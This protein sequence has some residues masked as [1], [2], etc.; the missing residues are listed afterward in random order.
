MTQMVATKR[1]K[2]PHGPTG[3]EYAPG[4]SFAALSERDAKGLFIAGKAKYGTAANKTD[5]PAEVMKPAK[6]EKVEEA[7]DDPVAPLSLSSQTYRTRDMTATNFGRTGE[8]TSAPSLR[9]G[10]QPRKQT[11]DD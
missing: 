9:R 10:R 7:P 1:V 2:Y 5:L 6:V 3:R 8:E 11:S 4:E